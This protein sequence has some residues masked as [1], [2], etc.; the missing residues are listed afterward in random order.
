MVNNKDV[1]IYNEKDKKFKDVY[2]YNDD[3]MNNADGNNYWI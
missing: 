2:V 3:E 1:H